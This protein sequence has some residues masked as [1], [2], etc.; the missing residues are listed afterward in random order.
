M[1]GWEGS[2]KCLFETTKQ[3][4]VAKIWWRKTEDAWSWQKFSDARIRDFLLFWCNKLLA[5]KWH[6]RDDIFLHLSHLEIRKGLWQSY[7]LKHQWYGFFDSITKVV[8]SWRVGS[9]DFLYCWGYSNNIY[10]V[11]DNPKNP[12]AKVIIHKS[13]RHSAN[14]IWLLMEI[15]KHV[16]IY[17]IYKVSAGND[18]FQL[19]VRKFLEIFEVSS[20]R[21]FP[22]IISILPKILN[23]IHESD[24]HRLSGL[25]RRDKLSAFRG[26]DSW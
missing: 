22:S 11:R 19:W 23:I 16:S 3:S 9:L 7:C 13:R 10:I 21:F 24:P 14:M 8:S 18:T 6:M 5:H 15:S 4:L 2:F 20:T 1:L 17:S 26:S 12:L 25:A